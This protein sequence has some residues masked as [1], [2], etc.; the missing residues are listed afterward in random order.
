MKASV[1][2]LLFFCTIG[3]FAACNNAPAGEKVDA[4]EAVE[5]PPTETAS[6]EAIS[7]PV[8]TTS[9]IIEWTGSKLAG[10]QHNG[11]ISL[12]D[13]ELTVSE[14]EV[15]GGSFTLDMNSIT[16][17]DMEPGQGKEK[18]EGHLKS[19]DFFEVEKY[20]TG[21]FEIA[22]VSPVEGQEGVTH[23]ITG[24][25]TLKGITKSVTI[26]AEINLSEATLEAKTPS[27]T[28]DRTE[29]D[30]KYNSG[31]LGT[32]KDKIINDEVA[33]RVSLIAT[34]ERTIN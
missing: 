9:S 20:P 12:S 8:N 28:I 10:K 16:D 32:A 23:N 27:F 34:P 15:V 19:G 31:L 30:I 21:K 3:F 7:Y 25:L 1:K 11:T 22:E 5:T 4:G 14:G 24:N 33:L 18:L 13:G 29:W 17:K 2:I 26:P 6:S